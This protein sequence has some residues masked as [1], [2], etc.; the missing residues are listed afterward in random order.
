MKLRVLGIIMFLYVASVHAQQTVQYVTHAA[1]PFPGPQAY[2]DVGTEITV[3]VESD[4]HHVSAIDKNGKLLWTKDLQSYGVYPVIRIKEDKEPKIIRLGEYHSD[5]RN[6]GTSH[7]IAVT[8]STSVGGIL[9]LETGDF[10]T[11][12]N[13]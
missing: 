3:Y 12:G 13:D 4:G 6:S 11:M 10:Q 5:D 7:K 8:F 1:W 2:K 9:S